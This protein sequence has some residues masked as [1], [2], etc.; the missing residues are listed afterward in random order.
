[1]KFVF[2]GQSEIFD[3]SDGNNKNW[4]TKPSHEKFWSRRN[5]FALLEKSKRWS[6][7]NQWNGQKFEGYKTNQTILNH[8]PKAA[9]SPIF[10]PEFTI[11]FFGKLDK[12]AIT[13]LNLSNLTKIFLEYHDLCYILTMQFV[14]FN[15]KQYLCYQFCQTIIEFIHQFWWYII[16]FFHQ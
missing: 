2:D 9:L 14:R 11:C 1:M 12:I 6:Y 7:L 16:T 10:Q 13:N 3:F 15:K 4:F 5:C 8:D